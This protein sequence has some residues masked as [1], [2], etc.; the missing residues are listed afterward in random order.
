MSTKAKRHTHKYR[1]VRMSGVIVWA[2]ALPNCNHYM[3]KHMEEM[4]PGKASICWGCEKQITLDE[5]SMSYSQ[6][7]CKQCDPD[8]VDTNFT[9]PLHITE[10]APAMSQSGLLP[11]SR[12]VP[13]C[14]E[15]NRAAVSIAYQTKELCVTCGM[16][17]MTT[18]SISL[19]DGLCTSCHNVPRNPDNKFGF[20][21]ICAY[22]SI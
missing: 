18:T 16:R 12:E 22:N 11:A 19:E 8:Y 5:R 14:K 10:P 15:C 2:C 3:P 21:T 1:Q 6:P 9:P 13:L 7:M 20:C 4:V 17:T